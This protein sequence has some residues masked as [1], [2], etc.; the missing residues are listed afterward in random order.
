V[1]KNLTKFTAEKKLYFFFIEVEICLSLGLH[2][3]QVTGEVFIPQQRTSGI[4][5]LEISSSL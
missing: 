1:T 4:A 2:K 3:G 5:E